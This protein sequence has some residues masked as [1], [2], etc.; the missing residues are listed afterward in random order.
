MTHN[1]RNNVLI[2]LVVTMM[3]LGGLYSLVPLGDEATSI[4]DAPGTVGE[5]EG[6]S[7]LSITPDI[8]EDRFTS[9]LPWPT[10]RTI[11]GIHWRPLG[12]YALMV[13][14][15]GSLYK[16][17][18][19][20]LTRIETGTTESLYDVAWKAD[21]SEALVVGNHSALFMWD[22]VA[23]DLTAV[24][25]PFD[26][27]FFGAAWDP[28]GTVAIVVGDLGY[29]ARFNGTGMQVMTSGVTTFIYRVMWRPGADHAVAIGDGGL[30]LTVNTTEVMSSTVLDFNWGLWRMDWA[31]D[32]SYAVIV[33]RDYSGAS[34]RSLVVRYNA[35]G[36]FDPIPVPGNPTAG[37]RSIDFAQPEGPTPREAAV[38][39]G[40]NSTVLVWSGGSL[41]D[42]D[43]PDD[44][45]LRACSWVGAT[46][47]VVVAGN[48][49]AVLVNDTTAWTFVSYDPRT[50]L[51]AI[52]WRPNGDYGLV[53][54]RGGFVA[55]V[56]EGGATEI[57]TPTTTD[58]Y[59]VDW[60]SDGSYA[61]IC[62]G[63]G[64][65][66]RYIHDATTTTSIKPLAAVQDLH[67][68]S[69]KPGSDVAL[70]VGDNGNVWLRSNDVWI[71]KKGLEARN[72]R[73]VAWRP[74]GA[75]A[76][77]VGVSGILLNYTGTQVQNFQP[78]LLTWSPLFS[79]SWDKMGTKAIVV[80][81]QDPTS[82]HDAIYVYNNEDWGQVTSK[83]G[84]TFYGCAFTADSEVGVAFGDPDVIIKFSTRTLEG[85]R[86]SFKSP[87]TFVQRGAMYPTGRA[88]V[89]AG[90]G[91]YAYLMDVAEF[92]NSPPVAVIARPRMS[93]EFNV[94][95]EFTLDATGSFD[96]DNDPMV[97]SWWSNRTGFLAKGRVAKVTIG[98]P[99][100][101]R[102]NLTVDD[103]KGHNVT[104]NVIIRL[105]VPN[106]PPVGVIDSPLEG[107]TF[108]S[109][110]VIVF[111]ASGSSDPN[112]D[113]ITFHWVSNASGDLGYEERVER[114]LRVGSHTIILWVE[115]T[116]GTRTAVFV[117]ITIRQANRPP[118]VYITNPL[119]GQRIEPEELVELNASYSNDPDGDTLSYT[120]SSD[121]DGTL[122]QGAVI[123]VALT[124]GPH[125]LSVSATDGHDH[126]VIV[127]INVTVEEPPNFPPIIS[128]T[129]PEANSTVQGV[130]TLRG[131]ATDPEGEGLIVRYAVSRPE[132]W[133]V[134][135]DG[136]TTGSWSFSWDTTAL[137][138]VQITM[139]IE[140]FDGVHTT[141]IFPQYFV[142]NPDPENT[143]PTVSL[144][145]PTPGKVEGGVLLEG[146]ASDPDGDAIELV[147]VRID[148]EFWLEAV[149]KNAWTYWDTNAFGDGS[150]TISVRSFDGTDYSEVMTY[151]FV[152]DNPEPENGGTGAP[153]WLFLAVAIVVVA[154][155]VVL[156]TRFRGPRR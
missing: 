153:I 27:R 93:D 118:F 88:V 5:G 105:V 67:G 110:D 35:T 68:V 142:D 38:I 77:I 1:S 31:P 40:E 98:E 139:F 128:L 55:R 141:R 19:S 53:V 130:V 57:E 114:T 123:N 132:N 140:A 133:H 32:G 12:D 112:G 147:E 56:S 26:Q 109:D 82:D 17:T 10:N 150:H 156:L 41:T 137:M 16:Y 143:P 66:L 91:G 104:A 131:L 124:P 107:E 134:V 94:T 84:T 154:V 95:A 30:L 119:E 87:Y 81:T 39:A 108:T 9:L 79:V 100:W 58:L 97:F 83:T 115:D 7:P 120:W 61:L 117:N 92:V 3:V 126:T 76:I 45:T 23:E 127:S 51:Q 4:S 116:Q 48:R 113:N 18:M 136:L 54:G 121:V 46:H 44:R 34:P 80:G 78:G 24:D 149:G 89:F 25:I 96:A 111:D 20:G 101:H 72:L 69:I 22:G 62:G 15:G 14:S 11:Y 42:L 65:V 8:Y 86:S 75:F 63:S 37:L 129:S 33:G 138:N 103:G 74:D 99:G 90:S 50:F 36:T 73:D 155:L 29:V 71:D 59:D 52:A 151:D 148:A 47:R 144:V 152:V 21:G 64:Q 135:E 146:L 85:I 102:I 106:Y 6:M 70:A 60:A 43:A 125:L 13:G 49:G 145:N 2:L 28:T 122:G